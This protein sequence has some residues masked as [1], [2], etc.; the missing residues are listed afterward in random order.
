[1]PA[2]DDGGCAYMRG[3]RATVVVLACLVTAVACWLYMREIDGLL[4]VYPPDLRSLERTEQLARLFLAFNAAMLVLRA[5]PSLGK[6]PGKLAAATAAAMLVYMASLPLVDLIFDNLPMKFRIPS[7][8][9]VVEMR[10]NSTRRV[11]TPDALALVR[12]R[13]KKADSS[14]LDERWRDVL[15]NEVPKRTA[16]KQTEL[17]EAYRQVGLKTRGLWEHHEKKSRHVGHRRAPWH[18]SV[19]MQHGLT[20]NSSQMRRYCD[21]DLAPPGAGKLSPCDFPLWMTEREFLQAVAT[22][23]RELISKAKCNVHSCGLL[24]REALRDSTKAIVLPHIAYLGSR[25]AL[26]YNILLVFIVA[27]TVCASKVRRALKQR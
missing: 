4:S 10:G 24:S 16:Q 20:K 6:V 21:I 2:R 3:Q 9:A 19:Q 13:W 23:Q 18:S 17:L 1:M 22:K 12:D 7:L 11:S 8:I 27:L 5:S 15:A 26:A 25:A 14:Q